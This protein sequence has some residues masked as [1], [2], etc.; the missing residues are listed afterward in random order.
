MFPPLECI[1]TLR[2]NQLPQAKTVKNGCIHVPEQSLL[3]AQF[4]PVS[5]KSRVNGE[6]VLQDNDRNQVAEET[7]VRAKLSERHQS[8]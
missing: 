5:Y 3:V 2:Q 1:I 4:L 7:V 6:Q 8:G